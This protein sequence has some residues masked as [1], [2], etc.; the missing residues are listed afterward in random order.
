MVL[1]IDLGEAGGPERAAATQREC[2]DRGLILERCGREDEIL[3][4]MPPLTVDGSVLQAGLDIV[5]S[6][7]LG[8][9]TA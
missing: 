9:A 8:T 6:A 7:M 4:L 5:E 1:G 2:F 3:K